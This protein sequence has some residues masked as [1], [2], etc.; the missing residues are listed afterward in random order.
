MLNVEMALVDCLLVFPVRMLLEK[1]SAEMLFFSVTVSERSLTLRYGQ[2][3]SQTPLTVSF[4][5][6]G[7]LV[8]ETWTH[9]V[10]QVTNNRLLKM[11]K[12][13]QKYMKMN[14]YRP[15]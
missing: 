9:L 8:A 1:R 4:R 2:S 13:C 15:L 6:E 11:Q 12:S 14:V 7:R 5:T 3:G 10:L